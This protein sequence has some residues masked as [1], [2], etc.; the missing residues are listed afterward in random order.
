[1]NEEDLA[2]IMHFLGNSETK[3]KEIGMA[4]GLK[5]NTLNRIEHE[6]HDLMSRLRKMVLEWLK[7][8]YNTEKFGEPTWEKLVAAVRSR[9]GGNNSALAQEIARGHG[10]LLYYCR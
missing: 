6:N 10:N 4:L 7:K 2:E 5:E 3:W 1:M 9:V 8:N